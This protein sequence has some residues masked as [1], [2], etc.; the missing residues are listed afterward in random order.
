MPGQGNLN[1]NDFMQSVVATGYSG[2]LS[3]EIFNDQFRSRSA[4]EVAIDGMRSL[5]LLEDQAKIGRSTKTKA[6]GS[7]SDIRDV[8]FVQYEFA[9][10]HSFDRAN[11]CRLPDSRLP[12]HHR[13]KHV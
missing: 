3:L 2:P 7:S 8:A 5:I 12:G 6:L 11:S 13:S 10:H 1:I 9:H 4:K